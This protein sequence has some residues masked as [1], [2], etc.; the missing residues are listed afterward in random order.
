MSD[1]LVAIIGR[2]KKKGVK[3]TEEMLNCLEKASITIKEKGR[4]VVIASMDV[5]GLYPNL[6]IEKS[7]RM[8]GKA[9]E[10]SDIEIID[11]NWEWAVRYV[12]L[13]MSAT[14]IV[15]EGLYDILPR[16]KWK[17]GTRPGVSNE[18]L[19]VMKKIRKK[20]KK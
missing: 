17:N 8:C 11:G 7:A 3:S 6:E 13:N 14:E 2:R 10:E 12:T 4:N 1:V 5:V 19:K 18:D 15:R 16:R 9:G 20:K